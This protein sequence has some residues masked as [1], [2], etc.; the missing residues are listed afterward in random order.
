[1]VQSHPGQSVVRSYLENNPS[2][3]RTGGMTQEVRPGFKHQ[4]YQ[5]KKKIAKFTVI[6]HLTVLETTNLNS[7]SQLKISY[8][9]LE[10]SFK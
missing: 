5:K 4:Y 1:V 7:K 6:S 8:Q 3:K 10:I 2:Q 9:G